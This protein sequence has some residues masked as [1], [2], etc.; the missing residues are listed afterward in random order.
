MKVPVGTK[1][2]VG[3]GSA[4]GSSVGTIVGGTAVAGSVGADVGG[5]FVAISVGA[6]TS[7][8]DVSVGSGSGVAA[9]SA[10][11]ISKQPNTRRM[12]NK[13]R[14]G[15]IASSLQNMA[16]NSVYQRL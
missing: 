7:G 13:K 8:A 12:T 3:V 16:P 9:G 14:D 15:S 10:Q 2:F 5:M 11:P 4:V 6:A 1:V